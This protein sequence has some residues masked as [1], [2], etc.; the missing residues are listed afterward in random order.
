MVTTT[1]PLQT[2]TSVQHYNGRTRLT[3]SCHHVTEIAHRDV[4]IGDRFQCRSA[5]CRDAGKQ[6]EMD[7]MHLASVISGQLEMRLRESEEARRHAAPTAELQGL[8]AQLTE[9]L[10]QLASIEQRA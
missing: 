9:A 7:A 10:A 8:A 5:D 1:A 3:L 4:E 6:A 2:V